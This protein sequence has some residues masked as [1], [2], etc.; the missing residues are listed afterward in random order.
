MKKL[1]IRKFEI[2]FLIYCYLKR[3]KWQILVYIKSFSQKINLI[4]FNTILV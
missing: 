4:I 2:Y 3:K 1:K